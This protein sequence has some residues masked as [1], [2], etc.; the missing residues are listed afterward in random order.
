MAGFYLPLYSQGEKNHSGTAAGSQFGVAKAAS[1]VAVKVL[2]DAGYVL[3]ILLTAWKMT[4]SCNFPSSGA[5]A[6]M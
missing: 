3:S 6:D 1:L 2:S 4:I 5:V